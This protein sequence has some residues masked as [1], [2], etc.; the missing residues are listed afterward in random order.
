MDLGKQ[1]RRNRLGKEFLYIRPTPC[2]RTYA[3]EMG[4]TNIVETVKNEP[5]GGTGVP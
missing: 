1:E 2:D 5:F 3:R 4:D